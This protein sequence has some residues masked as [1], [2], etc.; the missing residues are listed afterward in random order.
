MSSAMRR[1]TV[2]QAAPL[3]YGRPIECPISIGSQSKGCAESGS[4]CRLLG[5]RSHGTSVEHEYVYAACRK[6]LNVSHGG[7]PLCATEGHEA[8][9]L[10]VTRDRER[11]LEIPFRRLAKTLARFRSPPK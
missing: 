6:I 11:P 2:M 7:L 3:P 9:G 8:L 10:L 5:G 1:A 4:F